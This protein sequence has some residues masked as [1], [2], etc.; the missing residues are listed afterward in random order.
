MPASQGCGPASAARVLA[1]ALAAAGLAAGGCGLT[2]YEEQVKYQQERIDYIDKQNK[3]LGPPITPPP[4]RVG[5][6]VPSAEGEHGGKQT[7]PDF[8]LFLRPPLG[9]SSQCEER[10]MGAYLYRYKADGSLVSGML[11]ATAVGVS[12]EEFWKDL[13]YTF[14]AYDA[15]VKV[16]EHKPF[17]QEP[18][19]FQALGLGPVGPPGQELVYLFYVYQ[20]TAAEGKSALVGIAYMLPPGRV[21]GQEELAAID[22]SLCT[23]AVGPQAAAARQQYRPP[24]QARQGR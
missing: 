18:L 20:A 21:N 24:S 10:P 4:R 13:V 1:L 7:G 23:L 16:E 22:L 17:G 9:V 8:D 5:T 15:P 2:E 6:V 12:K 3:Y 11:V 14:G 19:Q